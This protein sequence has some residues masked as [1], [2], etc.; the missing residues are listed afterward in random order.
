MT[1]GIYS[2]TLYV[3]EI[4]FSLEPLTSKII[5]EVQQKIGRL[6]VRRQFSLRPVLI[7]VNGVS[8]AVR[9][10]DFFAHIID[11]SQLLSCK[12]KV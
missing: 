7:H 8:E 2:F 11:F 6:Q 1:G 4:K 12:E 9:E 5:T 10:K 3:C